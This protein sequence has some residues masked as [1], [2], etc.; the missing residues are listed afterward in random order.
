[1]IAHQ[2]PFVMLANDLFEVTGCQKFSRK[3]C[4]MPNLRLNTLRIYGPA[5]YHMLSKKG[6]HSLHLFDYDGYIIDS[7]EFA[8]RH[9]DEVFGS[10]YDMKAIHEIFRSYGLTFCRSI[11]IIPGLVTVRL[12]GQKQGHAKLSL[13]EERSHY[14]QI[15][16]DPGVVKELEKDEVVINEEINSLQKQINTLANQLRASLKEEIN[17]EYI[18][19]KEGFKVAME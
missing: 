5:L 16:N 7:E 6:T 4:P 3:I 14:I 17:S 12:M 15:L 8:R 19:A 10:V 13:T 11:T 9:Q 18:Q 1:M 2:L